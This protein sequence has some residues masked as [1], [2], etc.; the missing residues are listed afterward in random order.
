MNQ[1]DGDKIVLRQNIPISDKYFDANELRNYTYCDV[2]GG[3]R[4]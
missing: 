4:H 3:T 2:C 1:N